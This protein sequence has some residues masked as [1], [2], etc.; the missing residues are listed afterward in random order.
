MKKTHFPKFEAPRTPSQIPMAIPGLKLTW[1]SNLCILAID[2][3]KATL[4]GDSSLPGLFC[5]PA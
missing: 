2:R 5:C 1:S 3:A 4:N